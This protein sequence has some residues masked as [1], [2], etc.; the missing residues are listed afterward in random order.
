MDRFPSCLTLVELGSVA[1]C[2]DMSLATIAPSRY[3]STDYWTILKRVCEEDA[4]KRKV[5]QAP[6][7]KSRRSDRISMRFRDNYLSWMWYSMSRKSQ[8]WC[9]ILSLSRTRVAIA[10]ISDIAHR[11]SPTPDSTRYVNL[12]VI[13]SIF[14]KS[15]S[16]LSDAMNVGRYPKELS[17]ALLHPRYF[18]CRSSL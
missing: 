9:C 18:T 11:P 5:R 2:H 4:V 12:F 3:I 14:N 16:S 13:N 15:F 7:G 17:S 10:S 6:D 1:I 8:I